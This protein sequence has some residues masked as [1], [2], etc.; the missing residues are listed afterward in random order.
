MLCPYSDYIND[1]MYGSFNCIMFDHQHPEPY[2]LTV[3]RSPVTHGPSHEDV[4]QKLA[5]VWGPTCDS[6]DCVAPLCRL[7][8]ALDVGDWLGFDQMGAYT[9]CAASN[10]NGFETSEVHYTTGAGAVESA[11]VRKALAVYNAL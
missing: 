2:A 5:S 9:I 4:A 7:P 8:A 11:A 10:F 1:G 6:I 3:A